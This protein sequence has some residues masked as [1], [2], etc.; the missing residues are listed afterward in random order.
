MVS[1]RVIAIAIV[2]VKVTV[3][4]IVKAIVKAIVKVILKVI[5]IVGVQ[6]IARRHQAA[7]VKKNLRLET[8]DSTMS[9]LKP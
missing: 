1:A 4:V 5:V 3:K 8:R 6:V 9:F 7:N 2:I